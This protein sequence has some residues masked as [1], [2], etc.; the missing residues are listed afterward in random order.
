MLPL[1]GVLKTIFLIFASVLLWGTVVTPTQIVG[2]LVATSGLLY[3]SIGKQ[4]L[5]SPLFPWLEQSRIEE[6][7][8]KLVELGGTPGAVK[9]KTFAKRKFAIVLVVLSAV[10]GAIDGGYAGHNIEWDPRVYWYSAQRLT[11]ASWEE[12]VET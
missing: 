9:R 5:H 4:R 2:C 7:G 1:S 6:S 12:N 8:S 10:A 11:G 3:Y